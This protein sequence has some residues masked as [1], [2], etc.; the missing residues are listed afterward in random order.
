M[1]NRDIQLKNEEDFPEKR[2]VRRPL[3]LERN[4]VGVEN[5]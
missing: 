1:K 2:R 5:C 3:L 4:D